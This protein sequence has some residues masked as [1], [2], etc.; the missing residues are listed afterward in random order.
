MIKWNS[1]KN[2]GK[3]IRDTPP[4]CESEYLEG[5][6]YSIDVLFTDKMTVYLGYCVVKIGNGKLDSVSWETTNG[7][8][9]DKVTHWSYLPQ[10]PD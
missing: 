3:N 2:V 5:D 10:L 7:M 8:E 9:V 6:N 4:P 1:C